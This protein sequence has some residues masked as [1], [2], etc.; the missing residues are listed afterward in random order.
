MQG[1]P[2]SLVPALVRMCPGPDT[3]SGWAPAAAL[4]EDWSPRGGWAG[5]AVAGTHRP[6]AARTWPVPNT[7]ANYHPWLDRGALANMNNQNEIN[8]S[9]VWPSFGEHLLINNLPERQ[10]TAGRE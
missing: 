5:V 10:P 4:R 7:C 6:T 9:S 3:G 2:S 1:F 8:D